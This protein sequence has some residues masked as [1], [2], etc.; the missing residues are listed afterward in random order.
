MPDILELLGV[1]KNLILKPDWAKEKFFSLNKKRGKGN[2]IQKNQGEN[3]LKGFKM[4]KHSVVKKK[5][6]EDY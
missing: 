4:A 1:G 6:V 5:V 2:T 3:K